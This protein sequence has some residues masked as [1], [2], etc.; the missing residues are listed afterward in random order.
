MVWAP[1]AQAGFVGAFGQ[2]PAATA[3]DQ[4]WRE[5]TEVDAVECR[6]ERGMG[7][8]AGLYDASLGRLQQQPSLRTMT[9]H[10]DRQHS[11]RRIPAIAIRLSVRPVRIRVPRERCR[12]WDDRQ[13]Q[14]P[15]AV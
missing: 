12:H 4:G 13:R 2:P 15:F 9:F 1:R 3:I 11:P 8:Q 5:H 7:V 6:G 14:F 10:A